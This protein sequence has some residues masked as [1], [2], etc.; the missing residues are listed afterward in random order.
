M[1]CCFCGRPADPGHAIHDYALCGTCRITAEAILLDVAG[2]GVP[3]A[4][5]PRWV[6]S[7]LAQ[8]RGLPEVGEP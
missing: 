8:I 3:P 5:S 2:V 6:H 1:R 7:Q 4:T